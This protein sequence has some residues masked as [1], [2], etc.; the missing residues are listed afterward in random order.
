MKW[1]LL[2]VV[3]VAPIFQAVSQRSPIKFGDIPMEDMTMTS[4]SQD[5]SA[6]AVILADYGEAHIEPRNESDYLTFQRHMRIKILKKEGLSWAD[7]K[8]YL[9]RGTKDETVSRLKASTYN[10]ENGRVVETPMSKEN[11][12]K[13][14]YNR[15]YTLQKF[16]LPGVKVGSVLEFSYTLNSESNYSFPNW[17]FQHAIPVR[18]SE[19]WAIIPQVLVY[20]KYMQG[21]VPATVYEKKPQTKEGFEV[22]AFHWV[23]KGVPAFKKEPFMTCEDDYVS[24]INFELASINMPGK[25]TREVLGSWERLTS[26]LLDD[27]DF[28]TVIAKSGF[29]KSIVDEV[30][31]GISEPAKKIEALHTYVKTNVEWDRTE[32]FFAGN[33]KKILEQKKG[34]SGD[35]NLILASMLDK[36]GFEVDMVLLSTRDHGFIRKQFP[37]S[38]QFNYAIC[39]VKLGDKVLLLDATEKYLPYTLLP[40][41]C[42]NGEGLII[43]TKNPGWID[44]TTKTK[45]RTVTS[46]DFKISPD[47]QMNGNLSFVRSG[48]D[49]FDMRAEY[50]NKGEEKYIK[51]FLGS[52]NW[53]L[54]KHEFSAVKDLNTP[55]KEAYEVTIAEH[56]SVSADVIY[57]NPFVDERAEENPFKTEKREYPVDFGSPME[58]IYLFKITLPDGY[59]ADEIP[60]S[61]VIALPGNAGRFSY[62]ATAVGNSLSVTSSLQINKSLF[63]ASEY[64]ALREFYSQVVAKQAEQIVLKKK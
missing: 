4:Y 17:Q 21:Y 29:L 55:V 38:R 60:P 3:F 54:G 61:K 1:L 44:L 13:E 56:A 12:F 64:P 35:I 16:T 45:S 50:N 53:Q 57:V 23:C 22:D 58:K 20:E 6:E 33:L 42:L 63:L 7:V 18:W 59:V 27:D 48:Y 15:S 2:A 37:V 34:T 11:I 24:K 30:T 40:E 36:A 9:K 31:A 10:L 39:S 46:A 47:G 28:G 8:I 49:A 32:D 26:V 41:R 43:S 19:Y 62:N 51:D 52:R 5:S 25:P 14:K